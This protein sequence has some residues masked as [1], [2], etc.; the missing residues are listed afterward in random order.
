MTTEYFVQPDLLDLLRPID[1]ITMDPMNAR[2]HGE[3]SVDAIAASLREFGQTKPIVV[4]RNGMV[5]AGHGTLM[6]AERLGWTHVAAVEG[7]FATETDQR[8]FAITDNRTAE[9]SEF[10]NAQVVALLGRIAD[11]ALVAATGFTDDERAA[12]VVR[13]A[14]AA[15]AAESVVEASPPPVRVFYTVV[16]DTQEQKSLWDSF[17]RALA[18]TYPQYTTNG[19]RVLALLRDRG[20][21]S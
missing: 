21:I 15:A 14:D 5:V 10:D 19:Q 18:Q 11:D 8:A 2:K 1:S 3:R 17:V 6:A 16:F 13:A 4:G 12:L 7:Q 9:L 20:E